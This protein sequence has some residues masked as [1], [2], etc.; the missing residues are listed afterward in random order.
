ME[1]LKMV[2]VL[3]RS[4]KVRQEGQGMAEYGLILALIAVVLIAGLTKLGGGIS[5]IL[6]KICGALGCSA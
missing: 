2:L 1:E 6:A 4:L 3:L 5:G